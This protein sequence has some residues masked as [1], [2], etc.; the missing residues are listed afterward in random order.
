MSSTFHQRLLRRA[1]SNVSIAIAAGALVVYAVVMLWPYF[2]ATLVRGSTITA[3]I[4]VA[5]APIQG[6]APA[7]LPQLGSKVGADGVIM[8]IT[9]DLLDPAPVHM[10]EATLASAR[11]RLAAAN[12]Y[13]D[14]VQA[15]DN[16]RRGL[17]K[18]Y[19]AD[20]RADLEAE[21]ATR[22]ARATLL[23]AKVASA[24]AIA[25][26]TRSVSDNGYRSKDYLDD[27]KIRLAEAQAE[28]AAER[29]ALD[30]LKRRRTASYEGLFLG[31]DGSSLNWAYGDWQDSKTEIKG[32]HLQVERA[33]SAEIEAEQALQAAREAFKL[34]QKAPAL[35]PPGST[36]RSVIVGKQASVGPGDP[37]GKWID[38]DDLFVD[39]PISD[40]ALPLIPIDSK[41]EV[42]L[43][44]EGKWREAHV[45][46]LRGAAEVI[47][48]AD[49]AAVAKG[50]EKGDAQALLK[51]DA[52]PRDFATCP[53]GRA[54][55]VHF[56]SAGLFAV[57][58][59][60]LGLHL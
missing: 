40:A 58:L 3:W 8:E 57:L 4:H 47:D 13:L 29:M 12:D 2:A 39:A 51:L 10:A 21:I 6:R 28:L 36:I 22:E 24:V 9:N 34:K 33:R 32:A 60:R 41:A 27:S 35:A 50:R 49:L 43:E 15:L 55:Y 17:M 54:A 5:T 7:V 44:G 26:R 42:I 56:P 16:Q 37:I 46:A 38:C 18:R 52:D 30:R 53:V 59:G 19:A 23:T 25:E 11:T 31:A 48:M 45:V 20:Y 14:S 1:S